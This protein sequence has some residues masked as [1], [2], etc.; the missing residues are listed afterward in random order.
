MSEGR[1]AMERTIVVGIDGSACSRVAVDWAVGEARLRG[2]PLRVA[3]VSSLSA[4]EALA[5][6]PYRREPAPDALVKVLAEDHPA[7]RIEGVGLTGE[8]VPALLSVGM[9]ADL[10][11]LGTRGAGGFA[12]LAVGSVAHGVAALGNRPVVLVPDRPAVGGRLP[13]TVAI[14]IDARRPVAAALAFAFDA[15]E[16][17]GALLRVVHAWRLPSLADQWMPFALPEEDRGAWEDQEVQKLS[18][19]LRPWREKYPHVRVHEDVRLKSPSSALVQASA[20]AELLVVGR[21]GMALGPTLHAVVDHTECPVAVV[22][23]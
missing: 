15:A 2:L 12:G 16:R 11:V 6:W 10:M 17:R 9:W 22:P 4:E 13:R 8:A 5:I 18:D 23:S 19:V 21:T 20:C 7:L 3:H 14:G 1:T